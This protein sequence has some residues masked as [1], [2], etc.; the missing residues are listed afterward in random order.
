MTDVNIADAFGASEGRDQRFA[1]Y[2]PNQDK[3]GNAVAQDT[4][5]NQALTLLSDICGGATAMPPIRG[6]WLNAASGNLILEEPVLVYTYIDPDEFERRLAEVVQ[7]VQE[8]GKQTRQGQMAIE[9]N[10]TFYLIDIIDDVG[11]IGD[12]GRGSD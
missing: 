7:L 4:W 2:V 8:I 12:T 5:V 1:I 9:F 6:A 10:Q 3:D 11:G